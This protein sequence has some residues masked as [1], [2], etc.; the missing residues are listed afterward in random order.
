MWI[1]HH[2]TK[3]CHNQATI[4]ESRHDGRAYEVE[5]VEGKTYYRGR[6]FL[7]PVHTPTGSAT[8]YRYYATKSDENAE[9]AMERTNKPTYS[10]ILSRKTDS[11]KNAPK[12]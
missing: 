3:D 9:E 4:I 5:D 1:Q 11:N 7:R 6:R 12:P 2:Q 8:V 10:A